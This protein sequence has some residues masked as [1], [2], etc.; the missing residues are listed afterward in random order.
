MARLGK[1]IAY[2]VAGKQNFQTKF[3]YSLSNTF[4]SE[5]VCPFQQRE[6][7]LSVL[8]LIYSSVGFH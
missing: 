1:D 8:A 4:R 7:C 3:V 6:G 2:Y 5:A